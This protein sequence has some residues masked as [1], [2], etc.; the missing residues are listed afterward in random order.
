M[1]ITV[2]T[3]T[4]NR[5]YRLEALYQSLCK[6]S[7]KDF[8]WLIIDDGSTDDTRELVSKFINEGKINIRYF[9]QPNGGKHRAINR[10]VKEAGG[11]LFYIVDS[12]D[13]LPPDSLHHIALHYDMIKDRHDIGGVCGLKA[14]YDG[15]IVGGDKDFDVLECS[16][17][18]L[19]YKHNVKGD[20]AEVFLTSVM[21]KYPFPEIEGERFCPEAL[22][23]NRISAHYPLHYFNHPVYYCEYLEDG[24]TSAITRVRV[25]SPVATTMTYAELAKAPVSFFI[26]FRS[27]INY[28]RFRRY[29]KDKKVIPQLGLFWQLARPF[30]LLFYSKDKQLRK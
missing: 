3:P 11:I 15:V 12:D 29:I 9:T 17:F 7:Y 21:K 24:L 20:M 30:S 28:W 8:E 23:W 25:N 14:D 18:D 16:A 27:A 19:R 6:Q 2:F 22:I 4:Y 10:G 1:L 26:R 13:I 5:A